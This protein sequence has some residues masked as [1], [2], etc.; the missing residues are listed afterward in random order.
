ML[1]AK[2]SFMSEGQRDK[3]VSLHSVQFI[4]GSLRCGGQGRA[5]WTRHDNEFLSK[6]VSIF[7]CAIGDNILQQYSA[8]YFYELQT[9]CWSRGYHLSGLI[10]KPTAYLI[11]YVK[12]ATLY[13]SYKNFACLGSSPSY[14]METLHPLVS[15]INEAVQLSS[16]VLHSYRASQT[17]FKEDWA[18]TAVQKVPVQVFFRKRHALMS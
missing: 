8:Q 9:S 18:K 15:C 1:I 11:Q 7:N 3:K 12:W 17:C 2:E 13:S 14:G 16:G 6:N 5:P 4:W 10:N